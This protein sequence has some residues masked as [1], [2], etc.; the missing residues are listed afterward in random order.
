MQF[1]GTS[2]DRLKAYQQLRSKMKDSGFISAGAGAA[3]YAKSEFL[4][5]R[6]SI[7]AGGLEGQGRLGNIA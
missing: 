4:R 1:D 7:M 2:L 5:R 3:P 6:H